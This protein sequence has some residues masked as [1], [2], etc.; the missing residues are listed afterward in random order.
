MRRVAT[1]SHAVNQRSC[2]QSSV[3]ASAVRV[4]WTVDGGRCLSAMLQ[5][6]R[7]AIQTGLD[8]LVCPASGRGGHIL[9]SDGTHQSLVPWDSSKDRRGATHPTLCSS[10]TR[11]L[12]PCTSA[13]S[14]PVPRHHIKLVPRL[15]AGTCLMTEVRGRYNLKVG[16][17]CWLCTMLVEVHRQSPV[18]RDK[19]TE[20]STRHQ[21][22]RIENSSSCDS[23]RCLPRFGSEA[24]GWSGRRGMR[25]HAW[26]AGKR[27]GTGHQHPKPHSD[28]TRWCVVCLNGG[29]TNNSSDK[30]RLA[31]PLTRT[32][33]NHQPRA[34]SPI[35]GCF[36]VYPPDG[37]Q[38]QGAWR[39]WLDWWW[40]E[41]VPCP[42]TTSV[43]PSSCWP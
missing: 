35:A 13:G 5:P 10:T 43:L 2:R 16:R 1:M 39:S 28:E 4:R 18:W 3:P 27:S 33:N 9:R 22:G 37:C 34:E 15:V 36:F 24:V 38:A 7:Q 19:C 23:N 40:N 29:C 21:D 42:M 8:H 14:P 6:G 26:R 30:E 41:L 25:N 32:T 12:A 17:C 31:Y 20:G 11:F